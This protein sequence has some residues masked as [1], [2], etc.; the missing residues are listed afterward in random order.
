V[1]RSP[2][3]HESSATVDVVF[4]IRTIASAVRLLYR[5]RRFLVRTAAAHPARADRE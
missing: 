2:T 5:N 4:D 1:D 3:N